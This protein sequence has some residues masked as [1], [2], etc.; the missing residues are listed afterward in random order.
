MSET[1]EPD[2][3]FIVMAPGLQS[4]WFFV[5]ARRYWQ[6]FRPSVV[7]DINLIGF[8]PPERTIAITTL[9][10]YDTADFLRTQI[11]QHFPDAR[12]DE[13]IY[14]TIEEAQ[15]ALDARA[16]SGQRFG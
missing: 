10:R 15:A 3:H 9:A 1:P 8:I 13:L 14:D 6:R 2:F 4:N 16:A 7:D 12:H 5:A 11:Q